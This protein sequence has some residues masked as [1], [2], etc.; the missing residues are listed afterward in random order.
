MNRSLIAI[1]PAFLSTIAILCLVVHA[2]AEKE[3]EIIASFEEPDSMPKWKSYNDG[4]MGGQS[5][6][7]FRHTEEKTMLF[8]GD[9]SLANGGGF[10]SIRSLPRAMNLTGASGFIVKARGDGRT[11]RI[12]LRTGGNFPK[13][14][15]RADL[16]TA[17]G[18]WVTT[19]IPISN[20]R[21]QVWG[22]LVP[23]ASPVNP[24]GIE[25][26]A[27]SLADKKAGVFQFEIEYIKAVFEDAN[28][29]PTES[30]GATVDIAAD[31]TSTSPK[32]SLTI[33]SYD[34]PLSTK[35]VKLVQEPSRVQKLSASHESMANYVFVQLDNTITVYNADGMEQRSFTVPPEVLEIRSFTILPDGGIAFLANQNDSIYFVDKSGKH[36]KTLAFLEEPDRHIQPMTGIVVDGN[37][38]ISS[39]GQGEVIAVDLKTYEMSVFRDLKQLRGAIGTITHT[40]GVF[41][42]AHYKDIHSFT[43]DSEKIK[44]VVSTPRGNI[45]EIIVENDRLF[46]A[47][48]GNW[49]RPRQLPTAY[50]FNLKSGELMEVKNLFNNPQSLLPLKTEDN[51]IFLE[52]FVPPAP[53]EDSLTIIS[54][55]PPLPARLK[56]GERLNVTVEYAI[57][58]VERAQI[59][60]RGLTRGEQIPGSGGHSSPYYHQGTGKIEAWFHLSLPGIVDEV[61]IR[62]MTSRAAESTVIS[63]TA[64]IDAEWVKK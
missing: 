25:S 52:K 58:S 62:M 20:F 5:K 51:K 33:A 63:T 49:P 1:K 13:A 39:N 54:Y 15:Y 59:W 18:E 9:I 42:I 40:D 2:A 55:D 48:S 12:G 34:P 31:E 61:S 19:F 45:T 27:V 50:E 43:A 26:L 32:K 47:V 4:I 3:A 23:D 11:Y 21:A 7:S 41:Y 53:I 64:P 28:L 14:A 44:K 24:A 35:L 30:S 10:A 29:P 6:G 46:A 57:G 16:H 17:K 56:A 38:I 36:L 37:L 60:V 22:M 8:T